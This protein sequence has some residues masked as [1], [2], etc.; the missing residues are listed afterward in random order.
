MGSWTSVTELKKKKQNQKYD[1][2]IYSSQIP[3]EQ[4]MDLLGNNQPSGLS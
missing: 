3:K 4:Y 2:R 1:N